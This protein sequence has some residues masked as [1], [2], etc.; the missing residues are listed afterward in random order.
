MTEKLKTIYFIW[1]RP[2]II[3]RLTLHDKTLEEALTIA[4]SMG[5]VARK[6]YLPR[7]WNNFYR[8]EK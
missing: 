2:R 7:T 5:F 4:K 6:W 8:I 1:H 3:N